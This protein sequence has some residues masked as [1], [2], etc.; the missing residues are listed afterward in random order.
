MS[1]RRTRRASAGA[2]LFDELVVDS[3]AGGGGASLGIERALGRAVDVA[4]NHDPQ[5]VALHRANHPHTLHYCESVWDVDPTEVCAGRRVGLLWAS[6][7][8]KHFS[9]AKGGQPVSPRVRG[10]AWVVVRWAR[11][12]RPRLICLENVRE[13][14]TWGPLVP[15]VK[16][17]IVQH[18]ADGKPQMVPCPIRRGKTFHA[19]VARLRNLGYAVEWRS[20]DAADYGAPTHR[21]RLFLVARCD[22]EP[23]RWPE[24]TH[25]PGRARPWRTA[26]ECLDF[27]LACHSIFLTREQGRQVGC[28]RPLAENTLRRIALGLK[29]FVLESPQ[30]FIV[31]VDHGGDHFRGQSIE[32]PLATV[33]QRH[34]FGLAL[35]FLAAFYGERSGQETRG[36]RVDEPVRTVTPANQFG[37]VM[38]FLSPHF[39]VRPD[40]T[41]QAGHTI[42]EP[43]PTVTGR[44]TQHMLTAANLIH[45]N[46]GEKQW[47]DVAAPLR[48]ILAGA[49]HHGLVAAFLTKYYGTSRVGQACEEPLDTVTSADRFGLVTAYG[50][51]Y[52]IVDIGLRMLRPRELYRCQGFP[53]DYQIEIAFEGRPLSAEA[54]VKMCG[55][56]VC[57]P[58]AEGVV[59]ANA[60]E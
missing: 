40:G 41:S 42:A 8:C 16:D 18:G 49:N 21:R 29:R 53:E 46:H 23:I 36:Q 1:K 13:F 50:Q 37:L 48:T 12:V 6:P 26:A 5:A 30:P 9:R 20:L 39:G 59:R 60:C 15:R 31:R 55:N 25:G 38:A 34:G 51:E 22:G 7:D 44:A 52:A 3:F 24:P 10:L 2:G 43:F 17:G 27:S 47:S 4:V 19:W 35:P 54:Q 11:A 14:E 57:P 28:N 45:L 32:G 56:S 58:V 33:T